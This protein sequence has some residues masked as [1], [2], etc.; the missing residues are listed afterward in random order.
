MFTFNCA[1]YF[2]SHFVCVFT[3]ESSAAVSNRQL[4]IKKTIYLQV[5]GVKITHTNYDTLLS[6]YVTANSVAEP[7]VTRSS[8]LSRNGDT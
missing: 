5:H 6:G 8:S 2:L 3:V 7:P 4:K 1:I